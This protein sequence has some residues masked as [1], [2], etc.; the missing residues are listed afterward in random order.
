MVPGTEEASGLN[1]E[2]S[3]QGG[4]EPGA[5][6]GRGVLHGAF[7][8]LE[9]LARLEEA[10]L[11]QLAMATGL[12]KATTHRL[13][14]RLADLGV[15]HRED[16]GRYRMG[17]RT[18]RWGQRWAPA[19]VLSTAAVR[20]LQ[21]LAGTGC[22]AVIAVRDGDDVIVVAGIGDPTVDE[23]FRLRPGAVLPAASAAEVVLAA[24]D[25]VSAVCP[26]PG[27]SRP[28]GHSTTEWARRVGDARD[29]GVAFDFEGALPPLACVAA[30]VRAPTGAL[31]AATAVVVLGT[32][33]L[34]LLA[35][36]VRDTAARISGNLARVP[37][38]GRALSLLT[39]R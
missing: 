25:S 23:V 15:V 24:W 9:E 38:S 26:D 35:D 34:P 17:A 28:E 2:R 27:L 12:P 6:V 36:A 16:G 32:G 4:A 22:S 20:P 11:T 1:G 33:R 14:G 8:V 31:V 29:R 13:L 10:G 18:F 37:G 3:H 19:Q 39:E 21:G 5:S 30:P 7:A